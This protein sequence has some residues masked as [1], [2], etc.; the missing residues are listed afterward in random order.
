MSQPV[1]FRVWDKEEDRFIE[2]YNADPHIHCASGQ[3]N[4]YEK[5]LNTDSGHSDDIFSNLRFSQKRLVAQQFTG[6]LDKNGKEIYDGDVVA[7]YPIK[8]ERTKIG[9]G[10]YCLDVSKPLPSPDVIY[11]RG[12]VGYDINF[13]QYQIIYTWVCDAW[14]ESGAVSTALIKNHYEYEVVGNVFMNPEMLMK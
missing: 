3:I 8:F 12:I 9:E 7:L 13:C 2:W 14:K 10:V 4:C 11:A 5:N 6:L 1:K